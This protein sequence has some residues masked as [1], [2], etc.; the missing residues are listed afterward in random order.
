MRRA[1]NRVPCGETNPVSFI[2][3]A[4]CLLYLLALA[5]RWLPL[6][7]S[8]GLSG[9]RVIGLLL[10]SWIFYVWHVPWYIVLILSS[11]LVHYAAGLILAGAPDAQVKRRMAVLAFSVVANIGLLAYFKYAGFLAGAYNTVTEGSVVV[12]EVLLP[13]GISFYT[14]QSMSYT[15]DVYRRVI[16]AERSFIRFACYIAFF[17]QLV[18]GPIVRASAFLYQFKRKRKFHWRIFTE[19]SYLILRGLFLKMVVADN[20]GLVIEPYWAQAATEPQGTLALT[21]LFFFSCQLLCDFAG[22]V[23]IARGVA[24]HLGF[25]LPVNF[26]APFIARTFSEFWQRWH[27]TLSQ[28][29]RDYLYK[30]LGGSK[31]GGA[32]TCLNLLLVMLISGLWHGAAWTFIVWG[33]VLGL[34]LV[35]ERLLGIAESNRPAVSVFVWFLMVQLSWILSMGLFRGSNLDQGIA[36]IDHAIFGLVSMLYNGYSLGPNTELVQFGWW[37]TLPVLLLHFRSWLT[38]HSRLGPPATLERSA[39]AGVMLTCLLMLYATGQQFIYFQF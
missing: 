35:L 10:L 32:R 21:L 18:A 27:I 30:P 24:Y 22:Y 2:S 13:I 36:I 5:V 15:I 19:G 8:V 6:P 29:I 25:R 23:D 34:G 26:N 3:F 11:T 17:P 16:E 37:L 39:Y 20:L 33:A 38:E 14:F 4:F 1:R 28:W 9:V 7:A 31:H 12:P